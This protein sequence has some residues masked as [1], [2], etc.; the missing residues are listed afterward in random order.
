[1]KKKIV[2]GLFVLTAVI[3]MGFAGDDYY[4]CGMH[5]KST[6]KLKNN[7]TLTEKCPQCKQN[8]ETAELYEKSRDAY[9]TIDPSRQTVDMYNLLNCDTYNNN[10]NNNSN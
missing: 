4:N 9:C 10:S 6:N 3:G 7:R 1:M 5:I 2:M 8:N